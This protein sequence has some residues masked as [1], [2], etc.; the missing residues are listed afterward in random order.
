MSVCVRARVHVYVCVCDGGV[1]NDPINCN[2][3]E[4]NHIE[5]CLLYQ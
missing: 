3:K 5:Q 2:H 4:K 1:H